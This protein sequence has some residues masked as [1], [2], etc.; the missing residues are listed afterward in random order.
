[1]K[2]SRSRFLLGIGILV[3]ANIGFSSKAVIIKLMYRYHVD[4][5][6]VIAL[7]ML[8]SLPFYIA[9]AW[10]LHRRTKNVRLTLREWLAVSG[11]GI[12]SYYIS[13]MLDF[14]GLQ[15]ITAGVE[16][17]TLYLY[18][19]IVLILSAVFFKKK[20]TPPQYIALGLT[21]LGVAMA[22]IAENGVGTQNNAWLGGGL[23]FSAACTYS[24]YVVLTGE[25]VHK[26]GSA[27]FT[28]YMMMAAT[29]PAF[30]QS[31]VHNRLDIF[32]Y[33]TE[34][35]HLAIWMVLAATVIPTFLIVEGI[36]LVGAN[37]SGIIGAVGPVSMIGLAYVFLGENISVMQL[38]G[39]AIVLAG[40]FLITW[41][42]KE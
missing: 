34:V 30:I 5:I 11:L 29:V 24:V 12:L 36:R 37:N 39:T 23:V 26:I 40:V 25:Y 7:R 19:T 21:Y 9:I 8:I 41:K 14:L 31:V 18:P 17:L 2:S 42:G 15:Y 27:K 4:T 1:M 38:V 22:F 13:S 28:C 3:I 16:R 20:I 6:S 10:W 33:P 35:Y 32:N